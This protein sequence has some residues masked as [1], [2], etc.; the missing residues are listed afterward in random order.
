MP[1][2]PE[3]PDFVFLDDRR[4]GIE[5]TMFHLPP[6]AGAAPYHEWQSLKDRIV[7]QAERLHSEAGGPAL[8]VNVI[9]HE[10]QR[11]RK[12]DIQPFA[13]ELANALLAYSV[14]ERFH[15]TGIRIPWRCRPKWAAGILIHGSVDGIDKLW[16]ADEGGWVTQITS[17]H[18]SEVVRN[19]ASREPLARTRCDELWLVIVNDNFGHAA[20]AEISDEARSATYNGPFKRLLW[21]L[22]YVPRAI[23]LELTR[24]A[25]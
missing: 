11:L 21:L 9:F 25:A 19:K 2:E 20:Q 3:P 5:L 23:D 4:L 16:H 15:P 1:I 6:K 22:P 13:R 7:A 12:K 24:P 17:A 14:P 8:Y 10:R 18:I